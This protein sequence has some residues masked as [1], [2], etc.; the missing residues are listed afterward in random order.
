MYFCIEVGISIQI[1]VVGFQ[2]AYKRVC[3]VYFCVFGDQ[4]YTEFRCQVILLFVCDNVLSVPRPV[5]LFIVSSMVGSSI[6]PPGDIVLVE[7]SSES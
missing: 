6:G 4:S 1:K 7:S 5:F 3:F 2:S